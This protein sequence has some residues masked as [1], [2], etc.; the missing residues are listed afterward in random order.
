MAERWHANCPACNYSAPPESFK[1]ERKH[2]DA[3]SFRCSRC[4]YQTET[5]PTLRDAMH[6]WNASPLRRAA[7]DGGAGA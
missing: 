6:A 3:H 1:T 5:K 4:L 7:L 2:F